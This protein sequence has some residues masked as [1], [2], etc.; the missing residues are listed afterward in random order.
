MSFS[1]SLV[2][3][4]VPQADTITAQA[5][6]RNDAV[7]TFVPQLLVRA[8]MRLV[9]TA[10]GHVMFRMPVDARMGNAD[11]SVKAV[12][13][14]PPQTRNVSVEFVTDLQNQDPPIHLER[15]VTVALDKGTDSKIPLAQQPSDNPYVLEVRSRARLNEVLLT[16][17]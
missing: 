12:F 7:G 6:V 1:L 4:Y 5:Y 3:V 11:G 14:H 10:T 9:D 2:A 17:L 8:E 13:S 16:N 15:I